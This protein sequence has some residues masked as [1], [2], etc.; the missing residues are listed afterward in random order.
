LSPYPGHQRFSFIAS[1]FSFLPISFSALDFF[2]F[3][4]RLEGNNSY[5][6]EPG[7][8]VHTT[9]TAKSREKSERTLTQQLRAL[10]LFISTI[11][12]VNNCNSI[13]RGLDALFW[14]PQAPG[15][16]MAQRYTHMHSTQ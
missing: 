14:P 15:S 9:S 10:A 7:M 8:S 13:P 5:R 4:H 6:K 11:I 3:S 1:D 2:F 12:T 16:H